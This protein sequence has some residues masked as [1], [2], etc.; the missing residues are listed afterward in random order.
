MGVNG[1]EITH[2]LPSQHD[3]SISEGNEKR[4]RGIYNEITHF[5]SGDHE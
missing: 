5:L 1:N 2:F 3:E 4:P